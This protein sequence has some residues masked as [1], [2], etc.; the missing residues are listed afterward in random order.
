LT[1]VAWE[2]T[3]V[4]FFNGIQMYLWKPHEYTVTSKTITKQR[5][6]FQNRVRDQS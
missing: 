4:S 1:S 3:D 5:P 6:N 2:Y